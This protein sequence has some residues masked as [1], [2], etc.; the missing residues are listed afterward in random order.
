MSACANLTFR[1]IGRGG[2]VGANS[3]MPQ[4]HRRE[5]YGALILRRRTWSD[6]I[7]MRRLRLGDLELSHHD[8][9]ERD[10]DYIYSEIFPGAAYDHPH[11][12]LPERPTIVDVGANVGLYSIWAAR[13]YQPQTI[14]A[15]EA[16][17]S[18]F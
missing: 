5:C 14:L 6:M 2:F 17:P 18:T 13:K 11:I 10:I 15:F 3:D 4:L 8:V 1:A 9:F 16:S 12:K 7:P